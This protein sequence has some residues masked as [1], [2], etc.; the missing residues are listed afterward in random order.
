DVEFPLAANGV[1]GLE[2]ALPLTLALVR[3]GVIDERRAVE[4]LS[5]GPARA[6]G[7]PGGRLAVGDVADVTVID[8]AAE[9][10]VEPASF[11]SKGRNTPFAGWKVQG[12]AELTIVGGAIVYGGERSR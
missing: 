6:I 5:T 4:L 7:L 1:V 12:R 8:P 3:R 11:E 9:W 2:T 10:T